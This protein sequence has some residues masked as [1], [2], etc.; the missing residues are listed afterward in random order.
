MFLLKILRRTK[1]R[2]NWDTWQ[3]TKWQW[4]RNVWETCNISLLSCCNL[5]QDSS[6]KMFYWSEVA[7]LLQWCFSPLMVRIGIETG[8]DWTGEN[9]TEQESTFSWDSN[10]CCLRCSCAFTSMCCPQGYDSDQG[11]FTPRVLRGDSLG[12][13]GENA[14]PPPPL[15][16]YASFFSVK[17][18]LNVF[19][20]VIIVLVTMT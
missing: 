1:S 14:P 4:E 11:F 9:W 15:K 5:L 7:F 18:K 13:V 16:D 19:R 17:Q 12:R 10:P 2:H 8:H 3:N 20:K 6:I